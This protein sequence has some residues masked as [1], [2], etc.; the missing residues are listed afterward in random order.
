R[1]SLNKEQKKELIAGAKR[2]GID[3]L[4]VISTCNR[5]EIFAQNAAPQELIRLLVTYSR[6][7]LDEFHNYGFEKAGQQAIEHLFQVAV[8]LNSQILGD[9]QIIQQVKEAYDVACE[10]DAVSG[11]LH[12][13]MQH[14]FRAH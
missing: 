3:S 6:A 7:S 11:K 8:G 12:R 10:F 9:V 13:L 5:T 14:V 4:F 1:F 2:E